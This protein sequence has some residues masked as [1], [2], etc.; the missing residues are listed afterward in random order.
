MSAETATWLNTMTLIG[1]TAP[2][3]GRGD[4]WHRR[5]DLMV[6]GGNHFPH[7]IPAERVGELLARPNLKEGTYSSDYLDD[8]GRM[9]TMV[10]PSR[11]SIVRPIGAFGPKDKGAV[12]GSF[13][14]GYKIH[15][16]QEWLVSNVS[17]ILD[18]TDLRIGSA[19]LLRGGA[20]AWVQVEMPDSIV[21]PEGVTFRPHLTAATSCDG[22]LATGYQTGSQLVVCDNTLSAARREEGSAI[23]KVRHSSESLNRIGEVRDALQI[24]YTI[25]DDFAA[26]VAA[27]CATTVTGPQWDAF[28]GEW[29]KPAGD[30]KLA[31]TMGLNKAEALRGLYAH[32]ER[33]APWAGTAFGVLQAVN[34]WQHHVQTVFKGTS[35]S[36][37]NMERVVTGK[38]DAMDAAT[39][40]MLD[41]ILANA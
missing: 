10:D 32:D 31:V 2:E 33:V 11:K 27:L 28:V 39:I 13:R 24:V 6:D 35:R 40:G 1:F 36:G 7:E 29:A 30:S 41:K 23:V 19:G 4:A 15:R 12:L 18:E 17:G 37:R 34:T 26:E 8:E 16:Y 14:K 21:T 9:V 25:A 22:S 38:I 5:D 3:H 20:V